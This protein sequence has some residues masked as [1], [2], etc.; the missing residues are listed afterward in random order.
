[1]ELL[2]NV[3]VG[4]CANVKLTPSLTTN[5][6]GATAAPASDRLGVWRFA[7]APRRPSFY[8]ADSARHRCGQPCCDL[9]SPPRADTCQHSSHSPRVV[10]IWQKSSYSNL[11]R[12][13]RTPTGRVKNAPNRFVTPP[14]YTTS[15][16]VARF[17]Q[18]VSVL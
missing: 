16:D 2:R 4:A 11:S 7:R 6:Q 17:F 12:D 3:G 8:S 15:A 14:S 10:H 9:V 13:S 18:A 1:M 5:S